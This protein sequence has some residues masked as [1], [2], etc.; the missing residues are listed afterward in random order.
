[1]VLHGD[2]FRPA[3]LLGGVL[4]LAELPRIH[5]GRA[6]VQRFARL[7]HIMQ[8]FHRFLD[9]CVVIPTMDLI[10]IDVI[11]PQPLQ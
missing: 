4:R 2:K 1:M 6:D 11:H 10:Q 7:N 9:G 5:A 3:V 8:R